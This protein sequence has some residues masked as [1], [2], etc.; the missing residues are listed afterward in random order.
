MPGT[1]IR[2]LSHHLDLDWMR[3][4]Y[5]RT[6]KDGAAG[7]DGVTASEFASDLDAN[8]QSLLDRAKSGSYRA[9]PV[10]RAEIPKGGDKTR[11]IGIPTFAD[12]VLQRAVVM[13]LEYPLHE[14]ICR[15]VSTQV[16]VVVSPAASGDSHAR[17]AS[18]A[19]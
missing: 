17:G 19:A 9:P 7:I 11:S 5:R 18:S 14:P 6:R 4:A 16:T 12:K 2:S 13:L 3:E 1:A 8:L 15:G 10:R